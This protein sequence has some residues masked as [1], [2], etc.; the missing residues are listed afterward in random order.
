[1]TK[2]KIAGALAVLTLATSLVLPTAEAQARPRWGLVAAGV[3][4]GAIIGSAIASSHA[5]PVYHDGYRRC[6]WV[7][8]YNDF[9]YY[10]GSTRVCYY[11]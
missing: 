1:M 5:Y 9:G 2:T 8:Q 11:Y 10:V 7:R 4:G 6:R 3:V